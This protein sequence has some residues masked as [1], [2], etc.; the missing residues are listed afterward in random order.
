[1]LRARDVFCKE[2]LKYFPTSRQGMAEGAR[3]PKR[4][5]NNAAPRAEPAHAAQGK[6]MEKFKGS[7]ERVRLTEMVK[8][9]G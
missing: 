2:H 5:K 3:L 7:D 9:A 4:I 6:L 8:G 1:M